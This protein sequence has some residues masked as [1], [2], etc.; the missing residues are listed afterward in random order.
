MNDSLF[1]FQ[2]I[3]WKEDIFDANNKENVH[4]H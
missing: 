3:F 1:R 2:D 4:F